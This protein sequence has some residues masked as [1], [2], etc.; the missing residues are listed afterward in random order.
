MENIDVEKLSD[1]E[2]SDMF[3]KEI[4]IKKYD[5]LKRRIK[6]IFLKLMCRLKIFK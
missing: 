4:H 6:I 1:K 3:L 5:S 2:L